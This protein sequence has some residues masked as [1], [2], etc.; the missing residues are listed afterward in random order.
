MKYSIYFLFIFTGK[1]HTGSWFYILWH[2]IWKFCG[3]RYLQSPSCE[4]SVYIHTH[5]NFHTEFSPF[6]FLCFYIFYLLRPPGENIYKCER[7]K[8]DCPLKSFP[9]GRLD[10]VLN[11]TWICNDSVWCQ[12][13]LHQQYPSIIYFA[14]ELFRQNTTEIYFISGVA[15]GVIT[16]CLQLHKMYSVL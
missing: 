6:I 3:K 15:V 13:K 7:T 14:K 4:L 2:Y 12:L 11:D 9:D 5:T 8:M 1:Y 16:L 10:L